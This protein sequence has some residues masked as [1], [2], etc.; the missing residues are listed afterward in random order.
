[1][2]CGKMLIRR[3]IV[4]KFGGETWKERVFQVSGQAMV[5]TIV[6]RPL[7]TRLMES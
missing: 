4:G 5:R 1:M 6:A 7:T 2:S 3:N